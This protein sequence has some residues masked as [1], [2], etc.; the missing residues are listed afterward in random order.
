MPYRQQTRLPETEAAFENKVVQLVAQRL[1]ARD[2]VPES[3]ARE[4]CPR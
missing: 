4:E 1:R 2:L 3:D